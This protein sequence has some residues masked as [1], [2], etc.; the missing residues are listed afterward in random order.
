M[1]QS[2]G[3]SGSAGRSIRNYIPP[4]FRTAGPAGP[5]GASAG[6]SVGRTAMFVW[7]GGGGE[8]RHPFSPPAL[9]LPRALSAVM[10]RS[11][12]S[13]HNDFKYIIPPFL[14]TRSFLWPFCSLSL[15]LPQEYWHRARRRQRPFLQSGGPHVAAD[16]Q[17]QV[18]P[19]LPLLLSRLPLPSSGAWLFN[20]P[21][22][23][24]PS[25]SEA[26]LPVERMCVRACV[27]ACVRACMRACAQECA[28]CSCACVCACVFLS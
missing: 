7:R 16:S 2:I 18:P 1:G 19:T 17:H 5:A 10:I 6:R 9:S 28:V 3:R 24:P 8:R 20:A 26:P 11:Q 21:A 15:A 14:R 23:Y 12:G 4:E 13:E 27:C 22:R 25:P